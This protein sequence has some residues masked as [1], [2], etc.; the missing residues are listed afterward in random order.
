LSVPGAFS[1][2]LSAGV[3]SCRQIAATERGHRAKQ[4]DKDDIDCADERQGVRC[5]LEQHCAIDA[6]T[7]VE[8]L[9]RCAMWWEREINLVL[10]ERAVA[11][12]LTS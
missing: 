5:R 7:M 1:L 9:S 8:M 11:S 12:S 10:G 6:R 2:P 4:R 3:Y